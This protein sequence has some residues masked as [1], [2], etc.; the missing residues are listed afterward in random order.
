MKLEVQFTPPNNSLS[1]LYPKQN[2]GSVYFNEQFRLVQCA[3]NLISSFVF[4]F[5]QVEFE[6]QI[7]HDNN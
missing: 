4:P 6:A 3:P 2:L 1:I 5:L 7:L